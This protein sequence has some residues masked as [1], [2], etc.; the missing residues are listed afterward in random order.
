M[1]NQP[2]KTDFLENVD[3]SEFES[4]ETNGEVVVY[5]YEKAK[6]EIEKTA[7]EEYRQVLL[8]MLERNRTAELLAK[9]DTDQQREERQKFLQIVQE[10]FIAKRIR[11]DNIIEDLRMKLAQDLLANADYLDNET[12][13]L[14]LEKLTTSTQVDATRA[15]TMGGGDFVSPMPTTQIV[16]NNNNGDGTQAVVMPEAPLATAAK[17][18]QI[19]HLN[20]TLRMWATTKAPVKATDAEFHETKT[21][22]DTDGHDNQ[23]NKSV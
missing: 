23:D 16:L 9:I 6:N 1:E 8:D 2:Q 21:K 5:T 3:F 7:P 11:A 10:N 4:P 19:N 22:D 12:R 13:I 17:L 20:E 15:A 18:D 14:A